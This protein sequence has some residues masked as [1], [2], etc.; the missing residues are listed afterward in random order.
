MANHSVTHPFMPALDEPTSSTKSK[1][2]DIREPSGPKHT[3]TIEAPFGI[4]DPRVRP[5]VPPPRFAC[6]SNW[7]TDEFMDGFLRDDRRDPSSIKTRLRA[8]AAQCQLARTTM[9]MMKIWLGGLFPIGHGI[10]LVLVFH[11]FQGIGWEALTAETVRTYLDYIK[12]HQGH[13]WIA[14]V[15]DGAKYARERV[16]STV[17]TQR[18]RRSH[19]SVG[20]A[21]A[22]AGGPRSPA[23]SCGLRS[24]PI[25]DWCGSA[26][27]TMSVG[28]R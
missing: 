5:V 28:C 14:T 27:V 26:K 23:Y 3:C 1:K 18:P 6:S 16:N 8:M 25:G 4:D 24:R 2:Q 17:P 19:R 22:T 20:D 7:V 15:Q 11:F 12:E 10:W 9:D 21:H 13:M